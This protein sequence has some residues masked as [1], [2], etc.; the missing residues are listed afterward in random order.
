MGSTSQ[1]KDRLEKPVQW[2]VIHGARGRPSSRSGGNNL[3]CD[4]TERQ[5]QTS[6]PNESIQVPNQKPRCETGL[7]LARSPGCA[8]PR[9]PE[10]S[11]IWPMV[12][13]PPAATQEGTRSSITKPSHEPHAGLHPSMLI[14]PARRLPPARDFG[15]INAFQSTSQ[16]CRKILRNRC[17]TGA[18]SQD[19][20]RV[21][22]IIVNVGAVFSLRSHAITAPH[23]AVS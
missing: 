14:S 1:L 20:P 16:T 5:R 7:G 8:R 15:E 12:P 2:Q 3:M 23:G 19:L 21:L 4:A 13:I 10:R 6:W 17:N 9:L 18:F 22:P 11:R